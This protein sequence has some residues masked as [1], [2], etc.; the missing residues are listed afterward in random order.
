MLRNCDSCTVLDLSYN[1]LDGEGVL[2]VVGA[3]KNLRVLVLMGNPIV[4]NTK[5]YRRRVILTCK[6]LT[7]LDQRPV[8][9]QERAC[10]EAWLTGGNEAAN[11]L[12][13]KMAREEQAVVLDFSV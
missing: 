9:A 6:E 10:A 3:M 12:K 4:R 8:R 2:A 7:Y 11:A 1:G 5:Q 13:D